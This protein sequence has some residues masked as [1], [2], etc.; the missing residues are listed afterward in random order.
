MERKPNNDN[1]HRI[2]I[3]NLSIPE[4]KLE[5]WWERKFRS[6]L[7]E[8]EEHTYEELVIK[9]LEDYYDKNPEEV[10][11]FEAGEF[12]DEGWDGTVSKEYEDGVQKNLKRFFDKNTVN[13]EKYQSEDEVDENEDALDRLRREIPSKGHPKSVTRNEFEFDEDFEV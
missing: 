2:A 4:R 8:Y 5:R 10:S 13:L 12:K 9:M 1:L 11:R 7:K 3:S 6:P